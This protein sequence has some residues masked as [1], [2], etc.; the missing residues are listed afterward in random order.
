MVTTYVRMQFWSEGPSPI[1]IIDMMRSVG[2]RPVIG[3]YDFKKEIGKEDS[4]YDVITELHEIFKGTNMRY[5]LTT[6]TG[7]EPL[8]KVEESLGVT[9]LIDDE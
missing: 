6:K 1:K 2:Y 7:K 4:L 5:S 9:R 8:K 3:E